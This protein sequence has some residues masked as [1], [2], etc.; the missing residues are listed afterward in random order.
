MVCTRAD[1]G[2]LDEDPV[3]TGKLRLLQAA[4]ITQN[5]TLIGAGF[6]SDV[7]L[8]GDFA[9][10]SSFTTTCLTVLELPEDIATGEIRVNP[11]EFGTANMCTTKGFGF[12]HL[13]ATNIPGV[14][15]IAILNGGSV[16]PSNSALVTLDADGLLN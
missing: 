3:D 16:P 5:P 13:T 8:R 6:Q 15:V 11:D 12:G 10:V 4:P 2:G 14:D 7:A 1:C 9:I